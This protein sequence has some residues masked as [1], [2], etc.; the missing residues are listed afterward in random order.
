MANVAKAFIGLTGQE[1]TDLILDWSGDAPVAESIHLEGPAVETDHN[2]FLK[3]SRGQAPG[4]VTDVKLEDGKLTISVEPSTNR[5]DWTL[6]IGNLK[7]PRS[8][9]DVQ[10]RT[11]DDKFERFEEGRVMYRLYTPEATT[12]RPMILFL[13]G[14]GNGGHEGERDNN[15]SII[16]DYDPGCLLD[17]RGNFHHESQIDPL[18]IQHLAEVS[19]TESQLIGPPTREHS[20]IRGGPSIQKL[21]VPV[22]DIFG[23]GLPVECVLSDGD[24]D[25]PQAVQAAS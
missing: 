11:A 4:D 22:I 3:E 7:I 13:H 10:T 25:N 15:K 18:A 2:A 9:F 1:I 23:Q 17:R 6:V 20:V 21:T 14:G 8:D 16:T 12:P 19:F 5:Y 24:L